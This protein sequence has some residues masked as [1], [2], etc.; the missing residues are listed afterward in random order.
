MPGW[1]SGP[2][3]PFTQGHGLQQRGHQEPGQS[4]PGTVPPPLATTH[5]SRFV[6]KDSSGV[7]ETGKQSVRLGAWEEQ[8]LKGQRAAVLR[9]GQG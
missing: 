1:A 2:G 8:S 3:V 7:K 9:T 5:F 4:P 6:Y